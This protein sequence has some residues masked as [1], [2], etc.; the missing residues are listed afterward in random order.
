VSWVH[1]TPS[2][3]PDNSEDSGLVLNC[4]FPVFS[5]MNA[6]NMTKRVKNKPGPGSSK[7]NVSFLALTG[8]VIEIVT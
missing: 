6:T 7:I 2:Y 3:L 4:T 1:P 8:I 5:I